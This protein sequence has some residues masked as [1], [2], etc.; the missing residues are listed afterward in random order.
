[1]LLKKM[2]FWLAKEKDVNGGK[3]GIE[4]A[5]EVRRKFKN[6]AW[7]L[8]WRWQDT[9]M[10][11]SISQSLRRSSF[12]KSLN[13]P[14]CFTC[15]IFICMCVYAC[16]CVHAC[17][18]ACMHVRT[19]TCMHIVCMWGSEESLGPLL[20]PCRFQESLKL[21]GLTASA[22]P[23]WPITAYFRFSLC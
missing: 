18:C 21:S 14:L 2:L 6:A 10:L 3:F 5:A 4:K 7:S 19:C 15:F 11:H 22:L 23:H 13:Y 16:E 12:P 20:P 1:M 9:D 8:V 17:V